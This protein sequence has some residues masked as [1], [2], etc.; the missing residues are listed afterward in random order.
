MKTNLIAFLLLT[1]VSTGISQTN[2]PTPQPTTMRRIDP[3]A[4][5]MQHAVL[6]DQDLQ[7]IEG[8]LKQGVDI[9]APIGCG[10]YCPLDGAI[11]RGNVEMLKFFLAHGARPQ[12]R[13]LA[14]AAFMDNHQ[15][16]LEM[17]KILLTA[18]MSPNAT[19]TYQTALTS[20]AYEDNEKLVALRCSPNP[21]SKWT[22][23]TWT[24]TAP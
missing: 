16:A 24:V 14:D 5:K 11:S 10:T 7:E 2:Q 15:I 3:L 18:G 1:I 21:E 12:D 19:N 23:R 22:S 9:N 6:V 4:M 13:Q 20:A 8:L 17:A